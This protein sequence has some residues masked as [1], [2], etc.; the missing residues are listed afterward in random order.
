M[1]TAMNMRK[2]LPSEAGKL[3]N[4]LVRLT[5]EQR[6]LRFMGAL[7]DDAV[8][9]HCTRLNWFRTVVVGYFDAGVLRGAAEL[10]VADNHFPILCEVAITVETAWQDHGVATE[11]LRRVLVVARNRSARGVQI[12]CFGD[13]YRIQHVAQKFGAHFRCRTGESEAEISTPVPTYWSLCEEAIADGLGWMSVWFDQVS[14]RPR[15]MTP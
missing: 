11:L 6:S 5:R 13:N 12:N 15:S 14:L 10:Q 8:A 1:S 7:D 9:E 3:R 2:L 4:H